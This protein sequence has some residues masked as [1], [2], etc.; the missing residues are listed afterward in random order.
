MEIKKLEEVMGGTISSNNGVLTLE[1]RF[2]NDIGGVV[3][4]Y[5]NDLEVKFQ[6]EWEYK[7]VEQ[8]VT[9]TLKDKESIN[10]IKGNLS[11]LKAKF[12]EMDSAYDVV[13]E[14]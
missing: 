8:F 13:G 5:D 6:L 9:I 11:E 4:V 2:D 14:R 12:A 3:N 1:F 10:I 7:S